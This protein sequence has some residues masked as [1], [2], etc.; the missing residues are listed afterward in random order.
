MNY[1][2]EIIRKTRVN[3]LKMIDGLSIEQ[4]N[5]VPEGFNNNLIWNIGHL[6]AA[7]QNICYKRAGFP[8]IIDETFF[9]AYKS[10][11]KPEGD[12]DEAGFEHIKQLLISTID[13]LEI[14]YNNGIFTNYQTW[15]T[16]YNFEI[17]N[18]DEA[19]NF[20]PFHEGLHTG[21]IMVLKRTL[22]K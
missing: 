18:I 11:T 21:Y 3:V 2:I 15:A 14:D 7:Q 17:S 12:V 6:V 5:K 1:P 19:L 10:E 16:R 4:L 9:D 13:Q 8:F 20:L 22:N